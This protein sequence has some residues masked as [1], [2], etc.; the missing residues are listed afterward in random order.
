M[1]AN[2]S[3]IN[4][5]LMS[6]STSTQKDSRKSDKSSSFS[7]TLSKT[8]IKSKS[9]KAP[10]FKIEC[11]NESGKKFETN[12]EELAIHIITCDD[13]LKELLLY[14]ARQEKLGADI[15][16]DKKGKKKKNKIIRD[17]NNSMQGS[18]DSIQKEINGDDDEGSENSNSNDSEEDENGLEHEEGSIDLKNN[19][20]IYF[21]YMM[22]MIFLKII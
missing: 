5:T 16:N 7:M 18:V 4:N 21:L 17:I 1:E 20:K 8:K 9:G 13:C 2:N 3:M 15:L 11:K 19:L 10:K 14:Q 12:S 6:E 22:K